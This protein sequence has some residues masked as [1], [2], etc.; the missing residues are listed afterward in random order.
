MGFQ[1][2]LGKALRCEEHEHADG[3]PNDEYLMGDV[4]GEVWDGDEKESGEKRREENTFHPSSQVQLDMWDTK[5][6]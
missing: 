1:L 4:E 2:E 5:F 3:R 6:D